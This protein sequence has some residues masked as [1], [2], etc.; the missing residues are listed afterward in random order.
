MKPQK[1]LSIDAREVYDSKGQPMVEVDVWTSN[2]LMG[3]GASPCGT[4]VGK[5]E[6]TT[7]RDGGKR[8]GGLGVRKAVR[9]VKENITPALLGRRVDDQREI[10]STLVDLDGTLD[11]SI[12]GANTTYSVSIAVARAAAASLKLPLYA[13]LGGEDKTKLPIPA[14]NVIN[15][16]VYGDRAIDIQEYL[17]IPTE[18][19]SYA[20]AM[21]AGVE[22]FYQLGVVIKRD[23]GQA[24]FSQGHS[25]GYAAPSNDPAQ[26]L[27]LIL[28]A[29]EEAGYDGKYVIGLDCAA[30]QYYNIQSRMY[31]FMGK[32]TSRQ[33]MIEYLLNLIDV[34]PII[35]IEDPLHEDDFDG[36]AAITQ[37]SSILIVGDDLFVTNKHR[38]ERGIL[39]GGANAMIVKPNMIGTISEAFDAVELAKGSD[40]Q[41]IPSIRSSGGV[42]DPIS[43]IAVA[44]GAPLI[45]SGAPRSG[46]RIACHNQLLRIEER[47]GVQ[48]R[49][50][51]LEKVY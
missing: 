38:L 10:D 31:E 51:S 50:S 7:L 26:V 22:V 39:S 33:E 45:K 46:E 21:R 48:A 25:A 11:K 35:L 41:I 4:S 5:Y 19:Q 18:A 15:G 12:L 2:G 42:D 8:L 32:R 6:A 16:G 47:L 20:S 1:I 14:F 43:D 44:L 34:Y 37:R 29:V 40:Y 36:F 28:T 3:R 49:Y 9:N 24:L 23:F 27:K 13:Y 17:L 30:S